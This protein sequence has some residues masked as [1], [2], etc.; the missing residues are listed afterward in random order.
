MYI[1]VTSAQLESWKSTLAD[2]N[3]FYDTD[4]EYREAI[5][6]L[7][8]FFDILIQIDLEQKRKSGEDSTQMINST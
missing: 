3:V 2:S 7:T 6:N 4:D 5:T 8:G 1:K